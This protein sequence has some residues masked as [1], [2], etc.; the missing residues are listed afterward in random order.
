MWRRGILGLFLL[1][2]GQGMAEKVVVRWQD[3]QAAAS[4]AGGK[5]KL[6]ADNKQLILSVNKGLLLL[7]R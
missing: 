2:A 1:W 7:V 5:I 4:A 3:L 6:S